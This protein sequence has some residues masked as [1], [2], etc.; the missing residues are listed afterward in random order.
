MKV[1]TGKK[2]KKKRLD[3]LNSAITLFTQHGF[4]NTSMEQVAKLA[5]V[6]KQTVYSHFKNKD[7]LFVAAIESR[8][9]KHKLNSDLLSDVNNP[10]QNLVLF[11]QYF[12]E[13]ILTEE[14]ITVHK[15]CISQSDSH[16]EVSKLFYYAGPNHVCSLLSE[17]L[18]KVEA[19]GHY[20]FGNVHH[21]AVRLCLML[22]GELR[23]IL[24]LGLDPSGLIADRHE[25]ING[26]VSMF[27]SAY[28]NNN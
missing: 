19:L 26:C 18:V 9:N 12:N 14:A 1:N 16:P 3:I 7:N 17:Y 20:Q 22:Y 11:A 4:P 5:A 2:S 24:E 21:A 28:S 8:C 13:L 10:Q 27:L 25:Y 15:T 6:S 23:I